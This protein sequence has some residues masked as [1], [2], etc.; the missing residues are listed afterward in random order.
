MVWDVLEGQWLDVYEAATFFFEK[1]GHLDVPVGYKTERG[2][3]LWEWLR[4]QRNNYRKGT[5]P[6]EYIQKLEMI[7]IDWLFPAERNWENYYAEAQRFY[8]AHGNL[9][10]PVTYRT[11]NGLWLGR[12]VRRQRKDRSKL[13][14]FGANGD[15]IVRLEQVGMIWDMP[16]TSKPSQQGN[17]MVQAG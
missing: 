16:A 4:T 8:L 6:T 9:A 3:D 10:V 13:K 17:D 12:W 5:L 11:E 15:Q 1:Y 2:V 14:N 7:G